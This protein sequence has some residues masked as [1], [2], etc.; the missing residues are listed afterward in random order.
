MG[1][2]AH[3]EGTITQRKDGTWMG[4]I[5][6]GHKPDGSRDRRTVY[7]KTQ[8]DVRA[9]VDE[10][11]QQLANGTLTDTKLTMKAYLER[12]LSE[13]AR[14]VKPRTAEL[15]KEQAERYVYPRVGA[16]RLDKLTPLRIQ[17]MMSEIVDEVAQK[18]LER[19]RAKAAAG[20]VVVL[21][22]GVGVSTANKART[23][24]LGAMTQAVR[25]QLIPRNPVEAVDKLKE[26]RHEM[27]L[28]TAAEAVRFL[29]AAL[30]HRLHAAFYLLMSTGMRRGELLG[31][32]WR[33]LSGNVLHVRRSLTVR[34][35][36]AVFSTPK[37]EKGKRRVAVSPDVLDVLEQHR[38]RQQAEAEFLG[39][40]WPDDDLVFTSETGTP[41]HP[42]NFD[43]T[44]KAL[45]VAAAVPHA[46]LHDLRHLH[47]SLLVR[48][49]FDPR[50]I[51][52]RVGHTD[53]SFTLRWYAHAFEEQRQVTAMSLADLFKPKAAPESLN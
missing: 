46:R 23:L 5:S 35:G 40:A 26:Q 28:W 19:L 29:D 4:Q 27:V 22:E 16:V 42:R 37:S 51:A 18:E 13:K 53:S 50:S 12:W 41:I 24:L 17:T 21:P 11:K 20:E 31:L 34:K 14:Q 3:G 36:K 38:R 47:V 2:R 52:D 43:R 7:G 9:K 49:G 48:Q 10:I 33:D 15:Y 8:K 39:A 44:W 45:K 1:K 32:R 25:W 6:V 30:G